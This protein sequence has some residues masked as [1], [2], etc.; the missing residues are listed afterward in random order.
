MKDIDPRGYFGF[1]RG[2][3]QE[4]LPHLGG[5][6]GILGKENIERMVRFIRGEEP[7]P[8]LPTQAQDDPSFARKARFLKY[9]LWLILLGLVAAGIWIHDSSG[10]EATLRYLAS[11][12]IV[13]IVLFIGLDVI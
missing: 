4:E 13:G 7:G 11:I 2:A 9:A 1:K 8:E 3:V 5:H 10:T 12:L 6:G